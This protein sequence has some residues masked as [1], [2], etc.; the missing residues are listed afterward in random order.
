M[1]LGYA[2][3]ALAVLALLLPSLLVWQSR[4]HH[5]EGEYRVPGGKPALCLVF[6]CGIMII[7]V[8]FGIAAGILPA[9]G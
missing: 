2:G 7:L 4:K 6:A 8:Q 5:P 9:V 3:V 1:A